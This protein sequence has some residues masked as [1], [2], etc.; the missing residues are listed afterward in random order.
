VTGAGRA[1][2]NLRLEPRNPTYA[3]GTPIV[4]GHDSLQRS[5]ALED[6]VFAAYG[7]FYKFIFLLEL[8]ADDNTQTILV[9]VFYIG[10]LF[11]RLYG[12]SGRTS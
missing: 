12:G 4:N 2:N 11:G 9:F 1:E 5:R 8:K 3:K 10:G 6:G 7:L